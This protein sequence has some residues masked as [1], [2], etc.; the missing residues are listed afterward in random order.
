MRAIGEADAR[1][2]RHRRKLVG[3]ASPTGHFGSD[4]KLDEATTNHRTRWPDSNQHMI[5]PRDWQAFQHPRLHRVRRVRPL[6]TAHDDSYLADTPILGDGPAEWLGCTE[7]CAGTIAKRWPMIPAHS[8]FASWQRTPSYLRTDPKDRTGD[9][10][11]QEQCSGQ[12]RPSERLP[13]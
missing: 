8:V 11:V 1:Q 5:R 9:D 4:C 13:L 10:T 6:R 2:K 3:L 12:W 7:S